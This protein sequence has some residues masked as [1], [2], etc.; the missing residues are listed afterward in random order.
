[1]LLLSRRASHFFKAVKHKYPIPKKQSGSHEYE[2]GLSEEEKDVL[3]EIREQYN[4]SRKAKGSLR[5]R[6]IRIQTNDEGDYRPKADFQSEAGIENYSYSIEVQREIEEE[7][8]QYMNLIT[9]SFK[10]QAVNTLS[11][12]RRFTYGITHDGQE[13]VKQN[14]LI[15]MKN[16]FFSLDKDTIA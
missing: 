12:K 6:D 5:D 9:P 10:E 2:N 3:R 16:R 15:V 11:N 14:K 7:L 4:Q 13:T 8:N 1:M